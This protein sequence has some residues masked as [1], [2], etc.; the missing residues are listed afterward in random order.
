MFFSRTLRVL[1]LGLIDYNSALAIQKKTLREVISEESPH[2]LIVCEHT[3][4]ITYGRRPRPDNFLVSS[5]EI[6]R[7]GIEVYSTDRGG[8]ETYH[9]PGQAVFY[10]VFDLRAVRKDLHFFMR[11]LEEAAIRPLRENFGL[12]A[13]RKN[14]MTGVWVGPYKIGFIGIAATNWVTYHGMSLNISV[15]VEPFSL[16]RPCGL[17]VKVGSISN[18]FKDRISFD[19]IC[20]MIIENIVEIFQLKVSEN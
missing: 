1:N 17:D 8:E 10:P 5:D 14:G 4:V 2:T 11:S 18:F 3:P 20:D 15:D 13:Y 19:G 16:I 7:R 6:T 9:G 12:N